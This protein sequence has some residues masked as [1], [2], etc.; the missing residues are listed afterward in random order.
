[1][2]VTGSAGVRRD[3]PS[4]SGGSGGSPRMV[5]SGVSASPADISGSSQEHAGSGDAGAIFEVG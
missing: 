2:T 3:S 5:P 1:M 4:G